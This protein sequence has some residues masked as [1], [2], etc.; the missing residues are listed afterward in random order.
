MAACLSSK[1]FSH[2]ITYIASDRDAGHFTYRDKYDVHVSFKVVLFLNGE[3]IYRIDEGE[4]DYGDFLS[5]GDILMDLSGWM[6][7]RKRRDAAEKA[8]LEEG[9]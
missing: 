2:D 3:E 6:D 4:G 9:E 8:Q 5:A 7:S 1:Y